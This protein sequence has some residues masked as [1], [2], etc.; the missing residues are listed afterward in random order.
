MSC[1]RD[2]S[3]PSKKIQYATMTDARHGAKRLAR[4]LNREG[5]YAEDLYTYRCQSCKRWHLTRQNRSTST[6]VFVAPSR[7]LQAWAIHG[8]SEAA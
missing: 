8:D 2:R 5:K 1:T 3:C 4:N 6:L 7:A